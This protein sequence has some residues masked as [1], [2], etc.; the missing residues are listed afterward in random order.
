MKT[1]RYLISALVSCFV[2]TSCG[3]DDPEPD[4]PQPGGSVAVKLLESSIPDGSVIESTVS[5]IVLTWDASIRVNSAVPATLNGSPL[6]N[7]T[8][9]QTDLTFTLSL[10]PSTSYTLTIPAG[11]VYAD[12]RKGCEQTTVKFST[13]AAGVDPS[14]ITVA[15]SLHNPAANDAAKRVYKL[16]YDNYGKKMLSGTMGEVAWGSAY[17]DAVAAQA[18]K[19]PAVIGFDYIHIPYSPANWIDYGDIT[20]VKKVWDEGCI[21]AISWHWNVPDGKSG[22]TCDKSAPFDPSKVYVDGTAE[23]TVALADVAELA[24][25][26]KKLQDAGIA[27]MF[28]PFHEAAGDYTWGPWFWWG[29]KGTEVARQL[30]IWLHDK[31]T[32]DYKLNNI[33]WV[34]TTQVSDEGKLAA[35]SKVRAAYPGDNYVDIVGP[36]LYE[37]KTMTDRSDAFAVVNSAVNGKK[38]IA[39]TE[40]GNLIDPDKAKANNALWSFF[41]TWYEW[42]NNAPKVGLEWN[43]NGEWTRVLSNP[44]VANR[45]D[46]SVK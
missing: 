27:V 30:Y 4:G 15:S 19:Y 46:F 3:G 42:D 37:E 18:G 35:A 5:E 40:C 45:G 8:P 31:L 16:L 13:K 44:L 11:Y 7:Y 12:G 6:N 17:A 38:I 20:P 39:L 14:E 21:P 1:Y 24:E 28:R 10:E 9:R 43:K 36:D 26:M 33:I 25:S 29:T 34:W 32:N 23:N 41:M 22:Y 2:L